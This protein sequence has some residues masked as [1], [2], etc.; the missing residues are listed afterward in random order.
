VTTT[1]EIASQKSMVD[2]VAGY[3]TTMCDCKTRPDSPNR[4]SRAQS[5]GSFKK[6]LS[7]NPAKLAQ[8]TSR[9][10]GHPA[11]RKSVTSIVYERERLA[12]IASISGPDCAP[13]PEPLTVADGSRAW[14][15][16]SFV[17]G[18]RI[19]NDKSLHP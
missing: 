15:G 19:L 17:A 18:D 7:V 11:L 12:T 2:G 10:R 1:K 16:A 13:C 8:V 9:V 6:R 5:T 4:R 3:N 14:S